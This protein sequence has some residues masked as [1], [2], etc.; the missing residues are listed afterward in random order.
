MFGEF[1]LIQDSKKQPEEQ[2]GFL[3][4]LRDRKAWCTEV[5]DSD[6]HCCQQCDNSVSVSCYY[7]ES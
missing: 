2:L 7:C 3:S 4:P 1:L 6:D 5:Y